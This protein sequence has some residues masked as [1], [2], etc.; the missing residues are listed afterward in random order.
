MD[1]TLV[2]SKRQSISLEITKKA[3][4]LVRAPLKMPQKDIEKFVLSH[5]EW[6]GTH[7]EK[8]RKRAEKHPEPSPEKRAEYIALAQEILPRR[9]AHYSKI[10]DLSP[11]GVKITGA[12]TRFGSCSAKNSLCFSWRLMQYPPEAIDYVVVHE[13]AHIRHKNHGK[14]FYTLIASVLEDYKDRARLLRG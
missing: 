9:L 12:A 11:S 1:Y 14:E 5:T 4:L 6:I 13:L 10:M 2:R 3:Q 7:L 8:A